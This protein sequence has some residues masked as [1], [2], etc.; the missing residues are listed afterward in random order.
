MNE[1]SATFRREVG[2]LPEI[3]DLVGRFFSGNEG[4]QKLRHTVEFVLE[5]I[6]TNSVKYNPT[7]TSGIGISLLRL[8][9]Q[10]KVTLTDFDSDPF[11]IRTDAPPVDVSK[12]I[13][14]REPGGLG[15]HLVGKLMD[16]IEY[17]YAGRVS[18]ITLF[19]SL[20]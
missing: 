3:F 7:G 20:G 5:E 15:V 12:P 4:E 16:R 19:K 17:E 18:T 1:V 13:E 2:A 6:F 10:L 14:E 11:D 9:D 8:K